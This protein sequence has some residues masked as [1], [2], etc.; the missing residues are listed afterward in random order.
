MESLS[1]TH[2]ESAMVKVSG[3]G[4]SMPNQPH[5]LSFLQMILLNSVVCG[6]EIAAC[7]GFVYIPP[8]LL[9]AGY[10]EEEMNVLLGLG[11]LLALFFVPLI[12]RAS[13]SCRS[14]FGRRRPFILGLSI[15]LVISMYMIPF[16][17]YFSVLALGD[18][19]LSHQLG[20]FCL[21]VGSILLD[22]TSQACLTPCEAML[23]DMSRESHQHDR[24][25]TIYS[26]MV[27][28][29][30]ILGYLLTAIDWTSNSVG[31]YFGGQEASIFS[32]LI[33]IFTMTLT[34]T[35]IIADEVPFTGHVTPHMISHDD[36]PSIDG[37]S[38]TSI[39][40][41]SSDRTLSPS[42]KPSLQN[43]QESGYESSSSEDDDSYLKDRTR[44][45]RGG[46]RPRTPK[47]FRSLT[48]YLTKLS[49]MVRAR[50]VSQLLQCLKVVVRNLHRLLPKAVREML[51]FPVV[52]RYLGLAN[53]CSWTA[54]MGFNLYFTDYVGQ[55][56]YGGN[57]NLPSS[58][59]EGAAYD[60]GVRM[61][62]W[63]LLLHCLTSAI[64]SVIVE[65]LVVS[66]GYKMTYMM[67]MAS[68]CFAMAGMVLV[69][70]VVFVVLM[71]GLTGFAYST[72]TTIPFMLVSQY[73]ED[74]K[75]YF[76]DLP[77]AANPERGIGTDMAT[78]DSAYFLSQVILTA[79]MGSVVHITG[80]V[81]SYMIT[82]GFF[83]LLAC[84]FIE[85]IVV[86]P[87]DMVQYAHPSHSS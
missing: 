83:G 77:S 28:M 8:M 24:I 50:G 54:V 16:G 78:L 42:K 41:I 69:H 68:F 64:Y 86:C 45:L 32:I 48:R 40:A 15:V 85:H 66:Y 5:T 56:V 47:H 25:F 12:G 11:P 2:L 43:A 67:G 20:V 52:L 75:T 58:T 70:N 46:P 22:F 6:V 18:I 79:V 63:G 13:D 62:S 4:G 53:F 26:V 7:A 80:T 81:I 73:H 27:S 10:S 44:V 65:R 59:P 60:E 71:A 34:L 30:G 14:K 84:F 87:E 38:P 74:K 36:I 19:P 9:K 61:G 76:R 1:V 51:F 57:P 21:T 35:V 23:S 49:V 55:T 33:V 29:G 17:E 3:S 82:A 72:L 31:G 39:V 37:D